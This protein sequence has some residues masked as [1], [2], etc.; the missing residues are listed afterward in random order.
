MR[1]VK[2]LKG[3]HQNGSQDTTS[4]AL[5]GEVSEQNANSTGHS[6]GCREPQGRTKPMP[7]GRECLVP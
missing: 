2:N 4:K 5:K 1:D 7:N 6:R 3:K